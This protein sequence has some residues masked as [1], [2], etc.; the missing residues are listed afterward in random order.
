LAL[1]IYFYVIIKK[2][3]GKGDKR[4]KRGKV[5]I[6]TYG[7]TRK[8]KQAKRARKEAAKKAAPKKAVKKAAK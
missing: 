7:V 3:M 4:S 8:R 2:I 6:G 1:F 5:H